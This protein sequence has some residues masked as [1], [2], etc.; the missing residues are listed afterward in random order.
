MK[1]LIIFFLFAHTLGAQIALIQWDDKG[2][3]NDIAHSFL[4]NLPWG[5]DKYCVYA[6]ERKVASVVEKVKARDYK[7]IVTIG[8][9]IFQTA[10]KTITDIPIVFMG[11]TNPGKFKNNSNVTGVLMEVTIQDKIELIKQLIP[12]IKKVGIIL[13]SLTPYVHS[14]EE[15]LKAK[16]ISVE[17][18]LVNN[19]GGI[20][21]ALRFMT[22]IDLLWMIPD[23]LNR[24]NV[25][26]KFMLMFS[27]KKKMPLY[28]L[29]MKYLKMGATFTIEPS[30]SFVGKKGAKYVKDI[31]DGKSI[32]DLP[33]LYS[34]GAFAI[35]KKIAD[36]IRFYIP[37]DVLKSAQEIIK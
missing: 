21:T 25:S 6:D 23:P 26:F 14:L 30:I 2:I 16:K 1:K 17:P 37:E 12:A 9:P 33:V 32:K 7:C 5:V 35:N 34:K 13:S 19:P 11:V 22:N 24:D 36:K 15:K 31:V 29:S 20:N 10:A 27:L 8:D 3:Y 18:A 4:T 28:G